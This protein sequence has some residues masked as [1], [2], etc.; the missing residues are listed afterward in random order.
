MTTH[1][2]HLVTIIS[3]PVL[4]E[5]I[6]ADLRRLGATGLTTTE[7]RGEGSRRVKATE[8]PGEKIKVECIAKAEIAEAILS[9][10][11]TEYFTNY[12]TIAYATEVSVVRP[13]KFSGSGEKKAP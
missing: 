9:H 12:S 13:Q 5:R 4:L 7:V 6:Q 2:M 8:V 10:V 11:A 1:K 3:E